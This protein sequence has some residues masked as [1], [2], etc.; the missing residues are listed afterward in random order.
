[1][2]PGQTL[3]HLLF[4]HVGVPPE[5]M[6][7]A[8]GAGEARVPQPPQLLGSTDVGMHL[9]WQSAMYGPHLQVPFWQ[10]D[11]VG[12]LL[13]QPPQLLLSLVVSTHAPLQ[14]VW[15]APQQ[16]PPEQFG[17]APEQVL[18]QAPQLFGSFVK[19]TQLEPH[20]CCPDGQHEPLVQVPEQVL[21][22]APQFC[23][24][25]WPFEVRRL[26]QVPPQLTWPAGQQ[27]PDWQVA[28]PE[29]T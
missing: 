7:V 15:P 1:M 9:P 20:W 24:G 19:L 13:P 2:P 8:S 23:A 11:P 21:P 28:P 17:V 16:I 18:K 10:D 29:Q 5:Q 27:T 25:F 6:W 14:P 26:T 3:P 4:M 22:Q 12:H